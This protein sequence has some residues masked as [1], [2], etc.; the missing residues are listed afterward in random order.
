MAV[1][2]R[3]AGGEMRRWRISASPEI[4]FLTM[5]PDSHEQQMP[6]LAIVGA[7]CGPALGAD[8]FFCLAQHDA[9]VIVYHPQQVDPAKKL[10]GMLAVWRQE[11]R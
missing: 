7:N 5:I 10:S 6:R 3:L 2:V 11:H 8:S 1:P 9:S 4:Y